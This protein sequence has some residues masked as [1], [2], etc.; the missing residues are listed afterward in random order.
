MKN[1][2]ECLPNSSEF[3]G[4]FDVARKFGTKWLVAIQRADSSENLGKTFCL[5]LLSPY[6]GR[7]PADELNPSIHVNSRKLHICHQY[8]IDHIFL[9]HQPR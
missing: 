6:S 1:V 8:Y 4:A 7:P 3:L 5:T 2:H 9:K